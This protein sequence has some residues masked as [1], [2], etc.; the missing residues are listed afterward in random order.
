MGGGHGWGCE[1]AVPAPCPC[2]RS[3]PASCPSHLPPALDDGQGHGAL[4]PFPARGWGLLTAPQDHDLQREDRCGQRGLVSSLLQP[5][6]KPLVAV[7]TRINSQVVPPPAQ[8]AAD[9]ALPTQRGHHRPPPLN[10]PIPS[11]THST[12]PTASLGDARLSSSHLG[13]VLGY[14]DGLDEPEDGLGQRPRL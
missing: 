5:T 7:W 2:P 9:T 8:R 10:P 11:P 6:P 12:Q 1:V 14:R 3:L 4:G 13:T